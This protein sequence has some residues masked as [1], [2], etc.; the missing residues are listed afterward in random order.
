MIYGIIDVRE[1][2]TTIDLET[3]KK[4]EIDSEIATIAKNIISKNYY[5]GDLDSGG[6]EWVKDV[7]LEL[8]NAYEPDFMLI[9]FAQPYFISRFKQIS[10]DKWCGMINSIFDNIKTFLDKSGFV[11]VVVGLGNTIPLID[12]IDLSSLDGIALCGGMS[13]Y[14]AGLFGATSDDI[15]Y[16][17]RIPEIERIVSKQEFVDQF[18]GSANFIKRFPDYVLESKEGYTFK[19]FG[20]MTRPIYRIPAKH[21]AIP[22]YTPFDSADLNCITQIKEFIE[23]KL[24][25]KNKVALIIVE[26]I[27]AE[28]FQFP[29]T[30]CSNK[31]N[32]YTY[33]QAHAHYLAITTGKHFQYNDYPP[34]YRYFLEDGE[35]KKYPFSGP[36]TDMPQ[37]TVGSHLNIKSAAVGS[38]SV[39]THLASGADI[40]IEC[41]ARLLYNYGAMAIINQKSR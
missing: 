29:Y 19:A 35:D 26:G 6:I 39:L 12:Y 2:Q 30:M 9:N 17:K 27:S 20:D 33:D 18:G 31:V 11:P 3:G 21:E 28:E 16:L 24:I 13:A 36:F 1:W 14:Y 8:N 37:N 22:I 41:L 25:D 34:G 5:P 7:A 38:R 4:H 32:W 40:S 23:K 15:K 10:A